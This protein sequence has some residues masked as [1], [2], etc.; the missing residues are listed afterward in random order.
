VSTQGTDVN[1]LINGRT[2]LHY[3]A[4]YGQT[5]VLK[6]LVSKGADVN[7]RALRRARRRLLGADNVMQKLDQYGIAPII[8]AVFEGHAA[9]VAALVAAGA[10][11]DVKTPDGM[12]LI[13]IVQDDKIK[14]LLQ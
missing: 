6:F 4:D 14:K 7:V 3:A 11:K 12:S 10:K 5:E 2:P 1:A 9:A 13:E 8:P